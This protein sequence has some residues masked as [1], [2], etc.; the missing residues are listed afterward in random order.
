VSQRHAYLQAGGGRLFCLDLGSRT[1]VHWA[2][3]PRECGWVEW[4]EPLRI[5]P[6]VILIAR[7]PETTLV[8]KAEAG[9]LPAP[10]GA[11]ST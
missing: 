5:S 2:D 9:A 3:G 8:R 4:D 7:P 1:R 11:I 6:Y 10:V